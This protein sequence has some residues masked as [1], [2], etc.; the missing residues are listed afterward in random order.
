MIQFK[1]LLNLLLNGGRRRSRETD[2]GGTECF[3][4]LVMLFSLAVMRARPMDTNNGTDRLCSLM[5]THTEATRPPLVALQRLWD[6]LDEN[7]TK[8]AVV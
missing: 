7:Q 2:G 1:L 4:R 3:R 6:R 8:P 5:N